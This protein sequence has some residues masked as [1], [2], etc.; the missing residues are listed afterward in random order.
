MKISITN[1]AAKWYEKELNLQHSSTVKF[2]PRYGGMG[3]NI[4]GFSLGI[5]YD[6]PE[7]IHTSVNVNNITFFVESEDAWYFNDK[8]LNISLNEEL[9]EP[10]FTYI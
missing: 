4:P 1:E 6:K 9:N 8:D 5:N 2:F 10:E 3:G 7:N